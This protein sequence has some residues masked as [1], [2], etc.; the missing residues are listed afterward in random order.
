M[1]ADG[2]VLRAKLV[3]VYLH[4]YLGGGPLANEGLVLAM[5]LKC[6]NPGG[7]WHPESMP[8]VYRLNRLH[9]INSTM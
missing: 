3:Y 4:V 8:K 5:L 9:R 1:R 6:D 7:H 2:C